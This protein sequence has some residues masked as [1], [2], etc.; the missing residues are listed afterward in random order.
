MI[1]PEVCPF[2]G[3]ISK[4]GIC[5]TCREKRPYIKGPVCFCCGKPLEREETEYCMDCSGTIH[6]FEQGKSL[7]L[8]RSP[9]SEAVYRFKFK[10]QRVYGRVFAKELAGRYGEQI[11][12]WKVEALIP[13]PLFWKKRRKRGYNQAEVLAR[14]LSKETGIP[15]EDRALLRIRQTHPQKTLDPRERRRNLQNAF[16]VSGK[17]DPPKC[18]LILDDIYTT[19]STINKAAKMLKKAGVQKVYFLTISIGQGL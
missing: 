6:Y 19:G 9:V 12:R 17:W 3:Q 14:Y 16:A 10:N 13:I 11:R 2:C 15:V 7:F 18:V 4:N 1:Y 8:H 5:S